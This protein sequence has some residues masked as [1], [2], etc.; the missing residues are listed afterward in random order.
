MDVPTSAAHL[1]I[2]SRLRR[3]VEVM[4]YS[5]KYF[6]K[7]IRCVSVNKD[8]PMKQRGEG[9]GKRTI[10]AVLQFQDREC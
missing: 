9:G 6:I 2:K 8:W 5:S 7:T 10:F 4:P 3:W 1:A